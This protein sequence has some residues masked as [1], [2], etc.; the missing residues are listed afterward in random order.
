LA[1]GYSRKAEQA[2]DAAIRQAYDVLAGSH[3][4]IAESYDLLQVLGIEVL[5][6]R[7]P[8]LRMPQQSESEAP[9]I[10]APEEYFTFVRY[11]DGWAILHPGRLPVRREPGKS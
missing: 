9:S 8:K 2:S 4:S 3:R 6:F 7:T 11:E 5:S 10:A 1:E